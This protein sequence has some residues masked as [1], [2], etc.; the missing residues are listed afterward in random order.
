MIAELQ[1]AHAD[2]IKLDSDYLNMFIR[3]GSAKV[4]HHIADLVRLNSTA[5]SLLE[6]DALFA[7]LLQQ[8]RE[9]IDRL[10]SDA[11]RDSGC[12][13]LSKLSGYTMRDDLRQKLLQEF[14][15]TITFYQLIRPVRKRF[16]CFG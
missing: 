12:L 1:Q 8:V 7:F 11:F 13:F 9:S 10:D 5:T 15:G 3:L 16:R 6:R 4:R 2:R 14:I